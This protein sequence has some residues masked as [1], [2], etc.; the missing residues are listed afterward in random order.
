MESFLIVNETKAKLPSLPF[1]AIK[2][3]VMG[4]G[5]NVSLVFASDAK[6]AKLNKIYR[7]KNGTTDILSFPLS[8]KS[9]E[10]YIS[11]KES[12]R[13]AENFGYKN[14][15]KSKFIGFLFIHGLLHLKGYSHGSTMEHE[16]AR[17]VKKFR[18]SP[19]GVEKAKHTWQKKSRSVSTSAHIKSK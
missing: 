14:S 5:C 17:F 6:L 18:L 19:F 12:A 7:G 11:L 9:G 1:F 2:K 13:Q 4:N 16:E 15:K 3:A 10:I 8:E